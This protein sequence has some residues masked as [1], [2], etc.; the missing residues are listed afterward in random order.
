ML[1]R[2]DFD[3]EKKS[4]ISFVLSIVQDVHKS[5]CSGHNLSQGQKKFTKN[6]IIN[7]KYFQ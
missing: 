3:E 1:I 2:D 4:L 7:K 5:Q 6:H